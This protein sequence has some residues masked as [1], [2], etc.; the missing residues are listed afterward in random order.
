M[1]VA[2]I[3]LVATLASSSAF[4]E[5]TNL[6]GNVLECRDIVRQARMQPIIGGY[7]MSA[8]T[9]ALAKATCVTFDSV[10]GFHSARDGF[11]RMSAYGNSVQLEH[12][13]R[14]P[15]VQALARSF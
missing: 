4:A 3:C 11:G 14:F 7:H 13:S 2:A 5:C 9:F 10:W 15:R 8:G 6:G 1:R 12:Y